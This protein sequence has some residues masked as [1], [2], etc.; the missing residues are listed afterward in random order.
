MAGASA[1]RVQFVV[2]GKFIA[3]FVLAS[4]FL[5][6]G[7]YWYS[8]QL[9]TQK[10]FKP[11]PYFING[12]PG[13]IRTCGQCL[14][15]TGMLRPQREWHVGVP[16][17]IPFPEQRW[18]MAVE[19]PPAPVTV[20]GVLMLPAHPTLRDDPFFGF[21]QSRVVL[22][23]YQNLRPMAAIEYLPPPSPPP[24]TTPPP[25][26]SNPPPIPSPLPPP[27]NSPA[28]NY[29]GYWKNEDSHTRDVTRFSIASLQDKLLVHAWGACMPMD[30]DWH[31]AVATDINPHLILVP[32]NQG[33][34]IRKWEL[35]L[36][37]D[38]RMKMSEH[39]HYNDGRVDQDST[40]F[41]L[42]SSEAP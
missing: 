29:I 2:S 16:T 31:E 27:G 11:P 20:A 40:N 39:T 34:C 14:D 13:I 15:A 37:A 26:P 24:A 30:C 19:D 12:G 1:P 28:E 3:L 35:S 5:G 21:D 41:F 18:F 36:E 22:V 10:R 9:K 32:W 42:R 25:P 4:A 6:C 17:E 33:F 38:G 7:Y 8:Q 23:L